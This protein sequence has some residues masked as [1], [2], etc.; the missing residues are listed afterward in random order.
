MA[1]IFEQSEKAARV[2]EA[3]RKLQPGDLLPYDAFADIT[4]EEMQA[5]VNSCRRS[6]ERQEAIF[7]SAE[8]NTGYR[9]KTPEQ[10]AA[11]GT[12]FRRKV[13]K[14]AVRTERELVDTLNHQLP[15][16]AK[17]KRDADLAMVG[18]V[19]ALASRPASNLTV[20]DI[21][22]SGV[23]PLDGRPDLSK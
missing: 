3:I 2:R 11:A 23:K 9:R 22:V 7:L 19:R 6:V 12:T 21:P 13:H 10:M 4:K 16:Q 14:Q 1:T 5:I 15:E 18:V 17:I 8:P 20:K